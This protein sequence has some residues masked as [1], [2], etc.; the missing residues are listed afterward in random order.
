MTTLKLLT[1]MAILWVVVDIAVN[2]Q[3]LFSEALVDNE[4]RPVSA[5]G[6]TNLNPVREYLGTSALHC[7]T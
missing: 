1:E 7:C 5:K 3:M 2:A 4:T 6:K